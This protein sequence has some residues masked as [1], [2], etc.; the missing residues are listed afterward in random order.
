[1]QSHN[2]YLR[3]LILF[4][5]LIVLVQHYIIGTLPNHTTLSQNTLSLHIKDVQDIKILEDIQYNKK[6]IEY[7]LQANP[8]T[9][10]HKILLDIKNQLTAI[11]K[12]YTYISPG[13]AL[14]GPL[15]SLYL[16]LKQQELR[17]KADRLVK[18]IGQQ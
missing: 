2:F 14:L 12:K 18:K 8:N 5:I 7:L 9:T 4:F 6:V 17:K 15:S 13:L 11:E 3:D 16:V 10:Q 1:M